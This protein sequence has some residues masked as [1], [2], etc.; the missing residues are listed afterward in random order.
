MAKADSNRRWAKILMLAGAGAAALCVPAQATDF[1]RGDVNG[2]RSVSVSDAHAIVAHLFWGARPPECE[3]AADIK[4]DENVNIA[5]PVVLLNHLVLGGDAPPAPFPAPGS[6]P[7][8]DLPCDVYGGGAPLDDPA[9]ALRILDVTV[10]GGDDGRVK[11]TVAVSS[12]RELGGLSGSIRPGMALIDGDGALEALNGV[13]SNGFHGASVRRGSVAFAFLAALVEDVR[14]PPGTEVPLLELTFCLPPGARAGEYSLDLEAGELIDAATSQAIR[15][16]L[17]GGTLTVLAD[18]VGPGPCAGEPTGEPP[19]PGDVHVEF[20]VGSAEAGEDRQAQVPFVLRADVPVGAYSFS[21]DFD[22]DVLEAT[23]VEVVWRKPDGSDYGF[24]VFEKNNE[25]EQPGNGGVDEGWVLGA[26]VFDFQAPVTLP[27]NADNLLIRLHFDVR[28][29]STAGVTE[30]KFMDGAR[31]RASPP[32]QNVISA[33]GRS[34]PPEL[35]TSYVFINGFVN[36]LPD[37]T[38]FIRGDSNDDAAVDVGDARHVLGYLFQ[39]QEGPA[40]LDAADANDDGRLSVTDP[41]SILASL[42]LGSGPLPAPHGAA[43]EDPTPDGL[44][45]LRG[46]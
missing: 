15:P 38:L 37:G 23:E 16:V 11:V 14:I 39:G 22:E 20:R 36:V 30:V 17:E 43:G 12:S 5:D 44:E 29:G 2:D 33:F 35:G 1:I 28:P 32:V 42:F 46:S 9:A 10:P 26:A 7:T 4:E 41:I 27:A 13:D 24:K 40:C 3:A 31:P 18:V 19:A 21:L 34:Y 45:C 25:R 6:D 8:P